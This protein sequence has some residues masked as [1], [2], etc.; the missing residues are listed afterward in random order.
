MTIT[1]SSPRYGAQYRGLVQ[2]YLLAGDVWRLSRLHWVMVTSML[3]TL[4][5]KYDSSVSK[6]ARKYQATII[7]T[8]RAEK[9]LPG[10]R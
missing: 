6:M 1:P 7:D 9:M 4:A 3:K 2:Y 5:G 10:Q 8:V